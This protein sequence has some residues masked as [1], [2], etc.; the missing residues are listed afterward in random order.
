[1]LFADGSSD[2]NK[3]YD[4]YVKLSS[5]APSKFKIVTAGSDAPTF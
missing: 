4:I 3:K 2:W 1:M 5:G